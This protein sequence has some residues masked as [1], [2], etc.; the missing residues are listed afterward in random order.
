MAT[1]VRGN[2][3]HER[4]L[5]ERRRIAYPAILSGEGMKVSWGGIFGGVLVAVGLLL[6]LSALGVAVGVS[7]LQPGETRASTLGAGAGIWA[8]VSLLV[9]L[10]VGG[11]ASTR[12]GA[13][14]DGTTGFFEGALVWVVSVLLMFYMA[15][16][17]VGMLASGVFKLVGGAAQTFSSV[18]QSGRM[19]MSGGVDRIVARLKDPKTAEQ[20]AA[21]TGMQANEVQAS[22]SETAQRVENNRGN[23]TQAAAEAK[24]GLAQLMEKAKSSGAL[25]QK[26]EEVKPQASKAAWIAFGALLLSLLAAVLGAMAG[27]RR[28]L[29]EAPEGAR[30]LGR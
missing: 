4:R 13:I 15:G 24:Q 11:M 8:G 21:A 26:A 20:I 9:A 27:R 6:L 2:S 5:G 14:F 29:A 28:P 22:L 1:A 17:G 19:D 25:T 30:H 18:L 10:F 16:S 23:P 3:Y 7:A 12:I